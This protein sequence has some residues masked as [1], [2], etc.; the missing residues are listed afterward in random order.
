MTKKVN[1]KNEYSTINISNELPDMPQSKFCW[2]CQENKNSEC[3][4]KM[5]GS[6][7]TEC[8]KKYIRGREK[9]REESLSSGVKIYESIDISEEKEKSDTRKL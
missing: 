9:L 8:M 2:R 3:F 1:N 7:C 5:K 4:Y 6:W